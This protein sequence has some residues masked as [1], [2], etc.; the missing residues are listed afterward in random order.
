MLVTEG[1]P[2]ADALLAVVAAVAAAIASVTGFGIGSL[3]TPLLSLRVPLK[4]AV[5]AV[6][7]PHLV[8][9]AVRFWMLRGHVDR[10]VLVSFGLASAAGGLAGALLHT[11]LGSPVLS[12]VFGVL[13]LFVAIMQFSGAAERLRFGGW[14]AMGA[15]ALSGLLGGLVGNQGGIRSAGLL[16]FEMPKETFVATATAIG[17]MVDA[18]RMPVYLAT[19]GREL[20]HLGVPI[21]VAIAGVLVGT[22]AGARVMRRVPERWFRKIVAVVLAA[23]GVAMIL[24]A[25]TG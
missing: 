8:G 13:L 19:E 10:R 15:G 7:I 14:I 16:G 25:V 22:I 17:L 12:A 9:T 4:I 23:L 6:S 21:L 18:A 1:R 20:S 3:L 11:R 5:A 2:V 24:Q